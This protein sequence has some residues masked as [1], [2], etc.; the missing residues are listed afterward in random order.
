MCVFSPTL[1]AERCSSEEECDTPATL[2]LLRLLLWCPSA[3]QEVNA[4]SRVA[5]ASTQTPALP[6][7]V[8]L[9]GEK[10]KAQGKMQLEKLQCN[11]LLYDSCGKYLENSSRS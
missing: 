11:F 3:D 2:T 5:M 7:S 8:E 1:T 9:S 4:P 10:A 6:M